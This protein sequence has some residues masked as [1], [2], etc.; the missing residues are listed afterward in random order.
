[1][2]DV[3]QTLAHVAPQGPGATLLCLRGVVDRGDPYSYDSLAQEAT[4]DLCARYLSEFWENIADD[5][6]LLTAL[7]EVL[8]V[9]VVAGHPPAID[10]SRQLGE[11]FR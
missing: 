1:M 3:V 4:T 5:D 9:F 6:N 10:L 8:T 11:A 2:H 7:R